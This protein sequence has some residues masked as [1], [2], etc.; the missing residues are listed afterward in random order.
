MDLSFFAELSKPMGALVGAVIL[1]LVAVAAGSVMLVV[2][3]RSEFVRNT[4][5]AQ[6]IFSRVSPPVFY[7]GVVAPVWA[8]LGALAG[9]QLAG[10]D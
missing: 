8:V 4:E 10:M 7:F 5:V 2:L 9:Y 3:R 1:A 6:T